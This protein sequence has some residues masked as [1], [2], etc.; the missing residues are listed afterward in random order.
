MSKCLQLLQPERSENAE[1][2]FSL[3]LPVPGIQTEGGFHPCEKYPIIPSNLI[4][5]SEQEKTTILRHH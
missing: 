5:F 2:I 3:A 4:I 1:V